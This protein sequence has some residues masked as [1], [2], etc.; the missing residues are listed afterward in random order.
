M[1]NTYSRL[2][3]SA[4]WAATL[5]AT[6]LMVAKLFTWWHTEAVSLLASLVDS[7][8][9]ILAS[10]TNLI[11]VRYA[12]QPADDNHRFGHGKAESLAALAQSAFIIGSALFLMLNGIE[13]LFRPSPL[14][15]PEL[16]IVISIIATLL[17]ACLVLFQRW[18]VKKTGSQAIAADSLHYQTDL[19]MNIAIIIAL[20]L[21][22]YGI[23]QADALFAIAIALVISVSAGKMAF[24]AVQSLLDHELPDNE[25]LTIMEI[26]GGTDGVEGVH[27]LRTRQSGPTKFIQ[28][29][30]ELDRALKL[31]DAHQISDEVESALLSAFTDADI[32]IHQDPVTIEAKV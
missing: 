25:K 1:S 24:D 8:M 13:R 16:G 9:D 26:A 19:L 7:L 4:A 29:H 10:V 12:L 27:D 22:W 21:S 20:A 32:I 6:L 31:S 17:T 3:Q 23:S 11:V 15:E 14:N 30:L 2:V 18:V 28:L 5:V